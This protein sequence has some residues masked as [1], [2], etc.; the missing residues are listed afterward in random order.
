M[1]QIISG[2]M[3][4]A[5][6][7]TSIPVLADPDEGHRGGY[8]DGHWEG[9]DIHRFAGRDMNIWRRGHWIHGRHGGRL[10]WWWIA[11][12]VWYFYP[13]PVYPYPDPYTP[14][15]TI[16]NQPPVVVAPQENVAPPP[17][18][19]AQPPAQSWYYCDSA[20]GY[21]PYVPS[22][23]EPWRTVPAQP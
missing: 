12:G 19:P 14:P 10:G 21:Y 6:L 2:I 5:L 17:P 7:V 18:A 9:R 20:K 3:V 13:A 8:R 1:K 16:I 22:C 4:G 23:P 15:V 11:A